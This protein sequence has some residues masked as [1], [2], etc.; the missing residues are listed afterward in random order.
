MSFV[1]EHCDCGNGGFI[2]LRPA[3]KTSHSV[4]P[5]RTCP[6]YFFNQKDPKTLSCTGLID[7]AL[8]PKGKER[9]CP[10]IRNARRSGKIDFVNPTT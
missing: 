7:F 3:K 2:K 10:I 6:L 9:Q 4:F 5:C 1:V 8:V